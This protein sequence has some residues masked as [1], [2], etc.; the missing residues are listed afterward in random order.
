MEDLCKAYKEGRQE[1]HVHQIR[2]GPSLMDP[3][4]LFR[5]EDSCLKIN[6]K[7]TRYGEKLFDS[8]RLGTKS[9]I[10]DFSLAHTCYAYTLRQLSCS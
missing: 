2:A 4:V 10:K 9:C 7:L 5:K 3:I 1:V 6:L 8:G